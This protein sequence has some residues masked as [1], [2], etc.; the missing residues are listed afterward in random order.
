[1]QGIVLG[2]A[3]ASLP[4]GILLLGI[5]AVIASRSGRYTLLSAI[6][7][8]AAI[9]VVLVTGMIPGVSGVALGLG[10]IFVAVAF[11]AGGLEFLRPSAADRRRAGAAPV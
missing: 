11:A 3:F 8:V 7:L 5:A 4:A 6:L 1:V 10:W 2:A 9:P